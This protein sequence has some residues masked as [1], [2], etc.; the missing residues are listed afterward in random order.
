MAAASYSPM[1]S[2]RHCPKLGGPG[3]AVAPLAGVISELAAWVFLTH[4]LPEEE[5][6]EPLL[7]SAPQAGLLPGP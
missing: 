7:A 6:R 2:Q 4:H 3:I 1:A 5:G